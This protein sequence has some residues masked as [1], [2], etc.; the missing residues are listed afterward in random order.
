MYMY[1]HVRVNMFILKTF[2]RVGGNR[3]A[4]GCGFWESHVH[5][6][7]MCY[8]VVC[9]HTK[10]S[11]VLGYPPSEFFFEWRVFEIDFD[12]LLEEI[13][14]VHV[15]QGVQWG[16]FKMTAYTCVYK[17]VDLVAM[18]L[19]NFLYLRLSQISSG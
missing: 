13:L 17:P 1:T 3:T 2:P 6:H 18:S 15:Y 4:Y 7:S 14:N 16:R 8:M 9:L 12:K 10:N 11:R 19:R 5:V